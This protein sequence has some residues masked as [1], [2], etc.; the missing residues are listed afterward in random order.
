MPRKNS[1]GV[2]VQ[3][4]FPMI[5][6]LLVLLLILYFYFNKSNFGKG[7]GPDNTTTDEGCNLSL[8]HI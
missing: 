7:S 4:N 8:I 3:N 1:F 5:A 6:G 2:D